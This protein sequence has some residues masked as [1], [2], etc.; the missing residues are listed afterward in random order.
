MIALYFFLGTHQVLDK[1]Q[2][3]CSSRRSYV[4]SISNQKGLSKG[5]L[6]HIIALTLLA[7][8]PNACG[9]GLLRLSDSK[10]FVVCPH[11]VFVCGGILWAGGRNGALFSDPL[12]VA[13]PCDFVTPLR[14]AINKV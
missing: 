11:L 14:T 4:N 6:Y 8:L 7:T 2:P 3:T 9:Q 13:L 1:F 10:H 5:I 12:F